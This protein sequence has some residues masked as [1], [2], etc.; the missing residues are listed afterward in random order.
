MCFALECI[1]YLEEALKKKKHLLQPTISPHQLSEHSPGF[2]EGQLEVLRKHPNL[3]AAA[4]QHEGQA[5][6]VHRQ[7][8]PEGLGADEAA[9][10][11]GSPLLA[12]GE[13][14]SP[15]DGSIVASKTQKA[16]GA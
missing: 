9:R 15:F 11:A 14:L 4:L 7:L 1:D 13:F 6:G 5:Q 3:Q 16:K 12:N 8:A 2:P 10:P